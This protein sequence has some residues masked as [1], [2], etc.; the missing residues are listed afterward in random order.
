MTDYERYADMLAAKY[1]VD[2][3]ERYYVGDKVVMDVAS[4]DEV[5]EMSR[6]FW[7]C[8]FDGVKEV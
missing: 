5:A 2:P 8:H 3:L 7:E 1:G 4:D 6:L